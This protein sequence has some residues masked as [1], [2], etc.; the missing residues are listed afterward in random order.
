MLHCC[1]LLPKF[2]FS[3][4]RSPTHLFNKYVLCTCYV[5][6]SRYARLIVKVNLFKKLK[7]GDNTPKGAE[8][9]ATVW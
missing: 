1:V 8:D 7:V 9:E 4:Q 3:P 6:G 5:P 2:Y